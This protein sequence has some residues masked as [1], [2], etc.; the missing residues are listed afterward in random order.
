MTARVYDR[1][2]SRQSWRFQVTHKRCAVCRQV[3]PLNRGN[4]YQNVDTP[5][6]FRS[7]CK[8]CDGRRYAQRR[9]RHDGLAPLERTPS[10]GR[11]CFRCESLPWRRPEKGLCDCGETYEA[12]PAMT[13]AEFMERPRCHPRELA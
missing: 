7:M 12:E 8:A 2:A 9:Q 6:G 10:K 1:L 3:L 13:V 4:F 11:H 5:D